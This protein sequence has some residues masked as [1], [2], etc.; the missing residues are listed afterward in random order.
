MLPSWHVVGTPSLE[1]TYV[2]KEQGCQGYIFVVYPLGHQRTA[3]LSQSLPALT[4]ELNKQKY[5]PRGSFHVSSFYRVARKSS[6][7]RLQKQHLSWVAERY[8]RSQMQ[9]LNEALRRFDSLLFCVRD[10]D[11]WE[12][13]L[14]P[15]AERRPA[16]EV[17]LCPLSGS[18]PPAPA[19]DPPP[20]PAAAPLPPSAEIEPLPLN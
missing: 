19:P 2:K 11:C 14:S 17:D 9:E 7:L 16:P 8:T 18:P 3:W 20:L 10:P 5:A 6:D 1:L 4:H 13:R 15:E 12:Y